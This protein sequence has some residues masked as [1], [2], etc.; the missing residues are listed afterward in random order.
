MGTI[1]DDHDLDDRID[2]DGDN[3]VDDS[4][5]DGDNRGGEPVGGPGRARRHGGA[6]TSEE[7]TTPP[8]TITAPAISDPS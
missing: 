7:T 8:S 1:P 3:R 5:N 4:R 2:H 6:G